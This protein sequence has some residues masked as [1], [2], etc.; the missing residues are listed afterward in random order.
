MKSP[1]PYSLASEQESRRLIDRE[2]HTG[3]RSRIDAVTELIRPMAT[4]APV[5]EL[6]EVTVVRGGTPV[7]ERLSVALH[8]GQH[9]AIIG[10][11]GSGKS[12]LI[13]LISG[14]IYPS[15][16]SA[17]DAPVEIFGRSRWNLEELRTRLGVVS[18]ELHHRFV[19][20]SSMGRATGLEIV[21]AS[22]FGSEILFLHHDVSAEY[23]RRGLEAL[24]MVGAG[25]LASR[26]MHQVSSGE[27]RRVLIARALV[28][29]PEILV[30]DEP[31]TGLD[32]VARNDFLVTLRSL[33]AGATTLILVTHHVE[34][35]VPEIERVLVMSGGRIAADGT[36]REV[37]SSEVLSAAYGSPVALER[38]GAG[39]T[40]RMR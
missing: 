12:T 27:A 21:I 31:T 30:L 4:P 40:L 2:R 28:H 38:Q 22:F 1:S 3:E 35:I 13:K 20:G 34:E 7:I 36:P 14:Q 18:S 11:N 15:A 24:A 37:L 16:P 25:H 19:A 6:R 23:R 9:T 39:Y 32:L 29:Q 8:R 10:P 33:A 5:V 17:V 26:R